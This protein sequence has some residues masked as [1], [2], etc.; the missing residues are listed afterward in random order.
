MLANRD[1]RLDNQRQTRRAETAEENTA[2]VQEAFEKAMMAANVLMK[3]A[4]EVQKAKAAGLLVTLA[5]SLTAPT[6]SPTSSSNSPPKRGGPLEI[7]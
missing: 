7:P 5:E 6:N 1:L 2:A 3:G 4:E